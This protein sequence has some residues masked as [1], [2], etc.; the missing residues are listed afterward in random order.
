M[1]MHPVVGVHERDAIRKGVQGALRDR[2]RVGV[3]VN[4]DQPRRAAFEQHPRVAA[5]ADRGV[6]ESAAALGLEQRSHLV[7]QNRNVSCAF[8]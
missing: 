8:H 1:R 5:E 6:D 3:A 7:E 4:P 2:N